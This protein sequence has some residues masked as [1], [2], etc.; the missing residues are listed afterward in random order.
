VKYVKDSHILVEG[1]PNKGRFFI[2]QKGKVQ[3]IRE[4]DSLLKK[5]GRVIG[6]GDIFGV[7]PVMASYS[8]IETAVALTD[9][10]LIAVERKQYGDLIRSNSPFVM[11]IIHQFSRRQRFLNQMISE[12]MLDISA[13]DDPSHLFHV[14]EY[15]AK[16]NKYSQA[17][18]AYRQYIEHCP[19]AWD[20]EQA[21]E[22]MK[23]T[24]S[25][26][27]VSRPLYPED[28]LEQTYPKGCLLFAEGES[29]RELYIIQEG[30]VKIS[31]IMNNQEALLAVLNKG[32]IVGEMAILEDKPR[33][34]TAE[35]I[36]DCRV[37]AV[38]QATFEKLIQSQPELV[39]RLTAIMAERIWVTYKQLAVTLIETP[40]IRIYESL[41]IQL[42]KDRL[43]LNSK[44]PYKCNFGFHELAGMAGI[45]VGE[46]SEILKK[47]ISSKHIQL[48]DD[49]VIVNNPS[50]IVGQ[51]KSYRKMRQV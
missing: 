2:V 15:Y 13:K 40:I 46:R 28:T 39:A 19:G 37:L 27:T 14:A 50:D 23:T 6:P 51:I 29:K 43:D 31:K 42:E 7:I 49:K 8:Y 30:S 17:S 44:Q 45:P 3:I 48:I 38:N 4:A 47:I 1:K 36:N 18:Y 34:A 25:H 16:H 10:A 12:Q 21:R 11:K 41:L 26:S 9:V 24:A 32:D 35:V 5:D 20:I 33:S 22:K